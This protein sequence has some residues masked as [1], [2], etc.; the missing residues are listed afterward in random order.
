M[1]VIYKLERFYGNK[2]LEAATTSTHWRKT[3]QKIYVGWRYDTKNT[4]KNISTYFEFA[5]ETWHI[6]SLASTSIS[7]VKN[8]VVANFRLSYISILCARLSHSFV[9]LTACSQE[10]DSHGNCPSYS[11][12]FLKLITDI[13]RSERSKYDTWSLGATAE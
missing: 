8:C 13:L 9:S 5:L 12:N 11:R 2:A 3:S 6:L 7:C 10:W 4:L 1:Y